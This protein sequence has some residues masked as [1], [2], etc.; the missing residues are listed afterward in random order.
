L[1]Y[2]GGKA[3]FVP[4][5]GHR[6]RTVGA[7]GLDPFPSAG[8]ALEAWAKAKAFLQAQAGLQ[9]QRVDQGEEDGPYQG[10]REALDLEGRDLGHQVEDD[11]ID[12]HGDHGE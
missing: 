7:F 8:L 1:P 11:S 3:W 4:I 5:L 12:H 10:T 9:Q 2:R 6:V